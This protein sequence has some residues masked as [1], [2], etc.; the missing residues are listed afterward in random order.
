MKIRAGDSLS[1]NLGQSLVH[2]MKMSKEPPRT[3]RQLKTRDHIRFA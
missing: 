1:L 2:L 3:H